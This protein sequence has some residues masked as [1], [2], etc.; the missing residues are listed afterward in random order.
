MK[1]GYDKKFNKSCLIALSFKTI[2]YKVPKRS[3]AEP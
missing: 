1:M 2:G 3:T